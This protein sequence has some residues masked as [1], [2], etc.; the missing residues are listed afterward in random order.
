[1]L[2]RA[3]WKSGEMLCF[4]ENLEGAVPAG[5]FF[6]AGNPNNWGVKDKL[7]EMCAGNPSGPEELSTEAFGLYARLHGNTWRSAGLL[8]KSWLRGAEWYGGKAR[9]T[10]EASQRRAAEAWRAEMELLKE[11]KPSIA[12]DDHL[13]ACLEA[14]FS[15]VSWDS[16][17]NELQGD[18]P[19]PFSLVHGDAHPHN[20]LLTK[21]EQKILLIDFEMVGL[22]SPAQELGQWTISHLEPAARRACERGLVSNYHS[23]LVS[24]LQETGKAEE[25]AAFPLEACWEEY[26][27]GGAG[28]WAWFVPVLIRLCG[29]AMGQFFHDQLAA[30]LHDLVQDPS[31]CPMPRV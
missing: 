4:L 22:G 21:E 10:W 16:F 11:G 20:A 17:Q 2:P 27:A 1:M 30:F 13:I 24:V 5:V 3:T 28:R 25:A 29:P 8:E 18:T 23:E 7:P 9:D 31:R 19:Q 15:K 12:W 14:S 26:V 6:G